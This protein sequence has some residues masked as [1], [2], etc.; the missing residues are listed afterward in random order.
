M[1]FDSIKLE[2]DRKFQETSDQESERRSAE[3][4]WLAYTEMPLRLSLYL[5]IFA[6]AMTVILE[7]LQF[8]L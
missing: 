5:Y 8:S 3:K 7:Y 1:I 6:F 4:S 2:Y